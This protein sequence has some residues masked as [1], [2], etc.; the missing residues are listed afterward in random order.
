[1][2]VFAKTSTA[3]RQKPPQLLTKS[4]GLVVFLAVAAVAFGWKYRQLPPPAPLAPPHAIAKVVIHQSAFDSQPAWKEILGQ[5]RAEVRGHLKFE[6]QRS[7]DRTAVSISLSDLPRESI[8]PL[9][10]MVASAYVQACRSQWKVD[11]EHAYSTAQQKLSDAQREAQAADS[12]LELLRQRQ[13]AASTTVI[14]KP[15][16]PPDSVENPK[17][18][19]AARRLAGLEERRRVLLF[20]RTP[21]HPSVQEIEMH[22][23]DLRREMAT[24]PAR[25]VQQPASEPS[26]LTSLPP[27]PSPAELQAAQQEVA[28]LHNK[29]AQAETSARTALAARNVEL[30]IDLE[31]A[32]ALP[33]LSASPRIGWSLV[34][35]SLVTATT[36]VVALAIISFGASFEPALASVAELQ[37]VLPVPVF[38]VVPAAHPARSPARSALRRRVARSVAIAF[39]LLMLAAV[40][41]FFLAI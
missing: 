39:G 24:I 30:R 12:R 32:E 17:W 22:I 38:G 41:W 34:G 7:S 26:R 19:E 6:S 37:A 20:E 11:V 18:T 8:S 23:D 27:G 14:E 36:S 15:A 9:V 40:A 16:P 31:P 13:S 35:T 21:L 2:S 25:I 4:L 29:V 1:M 5:A 28:K 3:V 10:N 33:P